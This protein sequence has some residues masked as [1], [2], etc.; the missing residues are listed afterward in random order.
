M[1][2]SDYYQQRYWDEE[3]SDKPIATAPMRPAH[4]ELIQLLKQYAAQ[5][6]SILDIGCG[7]GQTYMYAISK[8]VRLYV[9]ADISFTA[10]HRARKSG[11]H[12]AQL[13]TVNRLPFSDQ[14]FDLTICIDVLEHLFNP[15]GLVV[16][17]RRTLKHNSTFIATVPNI[18]HFPHRL[19]MLCGKFVAGG[20]AATADTPWRDPHIRFFTVRTLKEMMTSAGFK[21]VD[22]IGN[23]TAF[24]VRFPLLSVVLR[25]TVGN[26]TLLKTSDRFETL[27]RIW[28]TLFAGRLIAVARP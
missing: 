23:N 25:K 21:E 17:V 12:V 26:D 3:R 16:E 24:L 15:E 8:P 2:P 20:L 18:A 7:D 13:D 11:I 28:P 19:R 6:Q 27:G 1:K 4:K 22:I 14:T 9:G 10:L 5:T